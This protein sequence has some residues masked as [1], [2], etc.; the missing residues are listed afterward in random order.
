[1]VHETLDENGFYE[2]CIHV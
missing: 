2:I 1:M